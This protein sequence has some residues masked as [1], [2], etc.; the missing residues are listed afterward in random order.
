MKPAILILLI[1]AA[2]VAQTSDA[3]ESFYRS[4]GKRG[5][6]YSFQKLE[7]KEPCD[8][9]EVNENYR[10]RNGDR[11]Q[12]RM[13]ANFEGYL[14]LYNQSGEGRLEQIFPGDSGKGK[15]LQAFRDYVLR[16]KV[17]TFRALT[18]DLAKPAELFP[19]LYQD[20]GDTEAYSLKLGRGECAV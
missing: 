17:E 8:L 7:G 4:K 11:F 12:L 18:A 5:V 9:I 15:Q 3:V 14:Y 16:F 6:L 10:F 20:W 1:A 2:A 19:E 13:A